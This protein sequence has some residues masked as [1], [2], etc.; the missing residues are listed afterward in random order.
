M[1]CGNQEQ[2]AYCVQHLGSIWENKEPHPWGDAIRQGCNTDHRIYWKAVSAVG[3]GERKTGSCWQR[4]EG[5]VR[6]NYKEGRESLLDKASFRKA[7][8]R[9]GVRSEDISGGWWQYLALSATIY[10]TTGNV[11][12]KLPNWFAFHTCIIHKGIR[13]WASYCLPLTDEDTVIGK[14]RITWRTC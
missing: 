11:P 10:W 2:S 3:G 8:R 12:G 6:C 7:Q 14:S 13:G 9:W 4:P 5:E 1:H